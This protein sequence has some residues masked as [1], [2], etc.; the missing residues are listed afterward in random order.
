M[1]V[2]VFMCLF[3]MMC[4]VRFGSFSFERARIFFIRY[5]IILSELGSLCFRAIFPNNFDYFGLEEKKHMGTPIFH[6]LVVN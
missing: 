6:F 3:C 2:F 4:A 5:S 1:F